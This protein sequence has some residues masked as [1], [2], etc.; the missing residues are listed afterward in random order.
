M[1]TAEIVKVAVSAAPY[2]I[3][4]PFDYQ[5]PAPLLERALPGVR[6]TVPFGRGNRTSEG[7]ILARGNGEKLPGLKPLE[8]VLDD[9]PVLDSQGIALALWMRQRYFCTM[10]EAVKTILPAGLWY[11]LREI[12]RLADGL[13][14]AGAEA[15]CGRMKRSGA[16]LDALEAHGG[17]AELETLRELCGDEVSATLSAMKRAGAVVCETAAQR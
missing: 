6:V 12:W 10:F 16:V 15:L 1:E 13:D 7:I 14:R 17:S 8:A 11:R 5:I 3:D 2:S 4:R 9:A